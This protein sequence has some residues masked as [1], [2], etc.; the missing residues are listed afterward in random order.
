M[1]TKILITFYFIS[2]SLISYGQWSLGAGIGL[3]VPITGYG[4]VVEPGATIFN[5]DAKR[6][7]GSGPL[8]VGIKTQMSRFAKDKNP[9]DAFHGAKLTVAP[10]IFTLD[11]NLNNSGTL[12]PY[13][14]GG[15]GL[16]F[17]ALSYNSSPTDIDDQSV[18]NVSFTMMPLIGVRLKAS[19]HIYPFVET[20]FVLIMDGPPVGFPEAEKLTGYHFT[21]LGVKYQF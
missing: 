15:L 14:S 16:S 7:L 6:S 4:K 12:Q 17:F 20:G 5:L 8:S 9:D 10:V 18:F 21:S 13:L 19:E 3:S 1:K 11:Y 2:L